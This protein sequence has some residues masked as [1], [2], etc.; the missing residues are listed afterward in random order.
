MKTLLAIGAHYDDCVFG[1]PGILLQGVR[2]HYR[3]VVL[4]LIGDYTNWSP[5][6]GRERE[7]VEGTTRLAEARGVEMRFLNFASH[8]FDARL[9]NK[10]TVARAVADIQPDVALALWKDDHHHDTWSP[11][12]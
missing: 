1:V 10:V 12:S 11:P 8:R 4:S 2:K 5:V 3:V 7:L 9:E 6:R